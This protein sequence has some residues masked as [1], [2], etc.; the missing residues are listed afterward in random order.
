MRSIRHL[1]RFHLKNR[2]SIFYSYGDILGIYLGSIFKNHDNI[3]YSYGDILGIYLDTIFK[4][5]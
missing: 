1:F 2:D 4:K 5:S 3:F